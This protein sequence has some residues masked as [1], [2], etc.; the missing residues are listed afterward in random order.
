[1]EVDSEIQHSRF[2]WFSRV[3]GGW[4]KLWTSPAGSSL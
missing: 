2:S 4:S 3:G 1:M